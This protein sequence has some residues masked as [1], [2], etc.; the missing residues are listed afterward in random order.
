MDQSSSDNVKVSYKDRRVE[1]Q[2]LLNKELI[3]FEPLDKYDFVQWHLDENM[4]VH[5]KKGHVK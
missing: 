5:V 4:F 3:C 1:G 2:I